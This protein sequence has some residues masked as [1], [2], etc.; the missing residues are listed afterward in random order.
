MSGTVTT[1][2]LLVSMLLGTLV[3]LP[4]SANERFYSVQD[5]DSC[6]SDS[7]CNS[8]LEKLGPVLS[9]SESIDKYIGADKLEDFSLAHL[10]VG[11][12]HQ[13]H[14]IMHILKVLRENKPSEINKVHKMWAYYVHLFHIHSEAEETKLQPTLLAHYQNDDKATG[15]IH[16]IEKDHVELGKVL[17]KAADV[18]AKID[19]SAESAKAAHQIVQHLAIAYHTHTNR[20][21]AEVVPLFQGLPKG[22]RDASAK[23]IGAFFRSQPDSKHVLPA[24]QNVGTA[25]P[26][27]RLVWEKKSSW[28]VRNVIAYLLSWMPSFSDYAAHFPQ[29]TAPFSEDFVKELTFSL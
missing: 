7:A 5:T 13:R 27:D 26:R 12:R 10:L 4:A 2:F 3:L 20:E 1:R 29:P 23:E 6:L 15:L 8:A 14:M 22:I 9:V 16:D 25:D 21:E 28:F 11:H 17:E 19:G 18:I 24:M